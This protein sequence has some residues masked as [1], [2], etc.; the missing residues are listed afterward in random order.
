MGKET[1]TVGWEAGGQ[2]GVRG[3]KYANRQRNGQKGDAI[4]SAKTVS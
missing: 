3:G 2:K 4:T 1:G